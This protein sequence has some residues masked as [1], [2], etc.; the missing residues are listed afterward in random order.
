MKKR[1]IILHFVFDFL[2]VG[3]VFVYLWAYCDAIPPFL[4]LQ[5]GA[6]N[7]GSAVTYVMTSPK[8]FSFPDVEKRLFSFSLIVDNIVGLWRNG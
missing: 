5:G 7:N 3:F 6:P 1:L 2:F 4:W 8:L